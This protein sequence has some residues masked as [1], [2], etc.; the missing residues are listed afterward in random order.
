MLKFTALIALFMAT[1]LSLSAQNSFQLS[2]AGLI[3]TDYFKEVP[4]TAG[5]IPERNSTYGGQLSAQWIPKHRLGVTASFLWLQ[6]TNEKD[7][8]YSPAEEL[9]HS[10]QSGGYQDYAL[11][12]G[13]SYHLFPEEKRF[14]VELRVLAGYRSLSL[15]RHNEQYI[16]VSSYEREEFSYQFEQQGGWIVMPGILFRSR[17]GQSPVGIMCQLSGWWSSSQQQLE[18]IFGDGQQQLENFRL[19]SGGVAVSAGLSYT[20]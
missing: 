8:F 18:V 5:F 4:A 17:S 2:A 6:R 12:V 20:F 11:L 13:P 9:R 1:A 19:R 3:A 14:Q 15:G 7:R 10:V 16:S